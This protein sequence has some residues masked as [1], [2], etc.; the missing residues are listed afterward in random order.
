MTTEGINGRYN[1]SGLGYCHYEYVTGY[2]SIGRQ[3]FAVMARDL[4]GAPA[5]SNLD[6]LNFAYAYYSQPGDNEITMYTRNASDSITFQSGAQA[7][8]YLEGSSVTVTSAV[9][10]GNK[11]VLELSGNAYSGG[12]T[13]LSYEG[14]AGPGPWVLNA[15]GVGMLTFFSQM[16]N[17]S[18]TT[19][20][21]AP[22][23]LN[24]STYSTTEQDLSWNATTNALY[25]IILRSGVQI[26]TNYGTVFCDM[27]VVPGNSYQYSVEAVG[28]TA[29]SA[30]SAS[31]TA[32]IS[33]VTE[34]AGGLIA[35]DNG[36]DVAYSPA[37][38][39]Q[40][41]SG[42]NGGFGYGPWTLSAINTGGFF[43]G[44]STQNGASIPSGGINV[45]NPYNGLN[46]SWGMWANNSGG[47]A[48][49]VA[50]RPFN[51][52]L[53][54]GQTF[55]LYVD[56]GEN[57]GREGFVLRTGNNTTD[58]N[59][60]KRFEFLNITEETYAVYGSVL[61]NTVVPWTDGG[62]R[63]DFTL[64]GVDTYSVTLSGLVSGVS[65]TL[66]GAL[67]GVSGS[68][69]NSVALYDEN[70]TSGLPN[71]D[72]Y[73]NSMSIIGGAQ[74]GSIQYSGNN[75][76]ISFSSAGRFTYNLQTTTDLVGGVWL[77]VISN[78]PGAGGTVVLTN[79]VAPGTQNQYYRLGSC[80]MCP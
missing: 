17:P 59:A 50:D 7:D 13:G 24:S 54:V 68:P 28:L 15:T 35:S 66:T 69:I 43:M 36:G 1:Q 20:P 16:I 62:V 79:V 65:Q 34:Q 45:Y 47:S 72:L 40:W 21:L 5:L 78:V 11:I 41:I 37:W 10:S 74:I 53:G 4:Y 46:L 48:E 18:S 76:V 67:Q 6:S 77:T 14:Q 61:T 25:Y 23:G 80:Y 51:Q 73:F 63:V 42:Y 38:P 60:G 31:I 56:T 19:A 52:P 22:T 9:A 70:N 71:Y 29:T 44:D 58:K 32:P 75:A 64:T 49:I 27:N 55:E 57:T 33:V 12:A 26:G 3:I 30:P 2:Q 39:Y 8:F